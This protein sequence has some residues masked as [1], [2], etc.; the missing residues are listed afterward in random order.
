MDSD[1][2]ET[3]GGQDESRAPGQR[4]EGGFRRDDD[5]PARRD[6]DRPARRDAGGPPPRGAGGF[7]RDNDRPPFRRDA[8][9]P[10]RGGAGGGFGRDSDRPPFR[11]DAGGPPRGGASGG[12]RR[13]NDRP[14]FRRDEGGPPRPGGS[15]RGDERPPFRRDNERP[16]FRRDNERPPFRRD[17]DAPPP[18][19]GAGGGFGR[20]NDRP[21]FR[22][23]AGGPPRGGGFGRDNDRPP[24]RRDEGSSFRPGG[25]RDNDRPPFRRDEGS[26]PPF[27]QDD[28][29]GGIRQDADAPNA[30]EGE[31]QAWRPYESP[32][33]RQ[34]GYPRGDGGRPPFRDRA[35]SGDRRPG[36]DRDRPSFGGREDRPFRPAGDGDRPFRQGRDAGTSGDGDRPTRGGGDRPYSRP[37]FGDRPSGGREDRPFRGRSDDRP[38]FRRDDPSRSGPRFEGG[39][40]DERP[41]GR[42][43]ERKRPFEGRD[44]R[45]PYSEGRPLGTA[46]R[47][48]RNPVAEN[49]QIQ[50][51]VYGRWPVLEALRAGNVVKIYL[52]AGVHDGADHLQEM[53]VVAAE[54]HIP[55]V[56][57][58]RQALDRAV[59]GAN[60]QGVAA[61][62]RPHQYVPF[63]QVVETAT[64]AQGLPLLVVFDG[65]QDPQNLGSILRT[66]E[67]AGVQGAVLPKHQQAGVTPAVVRASA[68][69]AQHVPTAEV[70]NLRQ[71]IQTLK[72][73]GYW[74]VGLDMDGGT[75][76]DNFDVDSPI[77]LIV[78]AEGRGLGRL[79]TEQCDYLVKLPMRGQIASLN[80]SVA[81][82][83]V[84]Y[85]IQ[86]RRNELTRVDGKLRTAIT[87]SGTTTGAIEPPSDLPPAE[88]ILTQPLVDAILAVEVEDDDDVDMTLV[89]ALEGE[90]A[91]SGAVTI[92][93]DS[94]SE[95]SDEELEDLDEDDDEDDELEELDDLDEEDDDGDDDDDDDDD[96]DEAL[97]GDDESVTPTSAP[98]EQLP[99]QESS[100]GTAGREYPAPAPEEH[101]H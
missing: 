91:T 4:T 28:D 43:Y 47:L 7:G 101:S 11:R 96:D 71:S 9:G 67:A 50:A 37:P 13:D 68:G 34:G 26:R 95:D 81:T 69:A 15:F 31:D 51:D 77:A 94:T 65:V 30:T 52:V 45:Q 86:R 55:I 35:P 93:I 75:D 20:D 80:A 61:V 19:D 29:R 48:G 40:P 41:A 85:E 33:P 72:D 62:A 83:I 87:R 88:M 53:Q 60:H 8:G 54:K 16:P 12:F 32:T 17:D 64:K 38:P 66:A 24:F 10:P 27:R 59:D 78:G 98:P 90:L 25:F 100:T 74:I 79:V 21:P 56:R 58:E 84:L 70:T 46:T 22:R 89:A 2:N 99:T 76:Y 18:R 82:G 5:R 63:E 6:D 36:G 23:D 14:P 97:E 57:V 3:Q 73:A 92:E 39:P 1:G 42:P 44:D 49:E